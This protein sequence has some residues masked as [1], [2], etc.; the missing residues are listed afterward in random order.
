M[1]RAIRSSM[2]RHWRRA[3]ALS[4]AACFLATASP[5]GATAKPAS[6]NDYA[7]TA[8]A[9]ALFAGMRLFYARRF[10]EAQA[11]FEQ[12]LGIVE[13][14]TLAISFMTMALVHST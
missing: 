1:R 12:S 9:N 6:R 10:R 2:Q 8:F 11:E 7:N 14:N 4:L 3:A 5:S 13:D